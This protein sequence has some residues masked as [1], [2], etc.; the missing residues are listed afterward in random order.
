MNT[1]DLYLATLISFGWL[2]AVHDG[3]GIWGQF[4][5]H[6]SSP[7]TLISPRNTNNMTDE[8]Q[9]QRVPL[10]TNEQTACSPEDPGFDWRGVVIRAPSRVMLPSNSELVIPICGL[11]LVDTAKTLKHPGPKVLIIIDSVSGQIYKGP[12]VKPILEP[13]IPPPPSRS[14]SPS[15]KSAFGGYFNVNAAAYVDFPK[16]PARYRLKIE[17]AGYQSN[18]VTISIVEQP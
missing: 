9:F 5:L 18:E 17:Y 13:T 4:S 6:Q 15:T 11:Y 10:D 16:R 3:G 8:S 7:T 2:T 1:S 14:I 12:L